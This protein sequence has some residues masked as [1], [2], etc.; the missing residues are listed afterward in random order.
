MSSVTWEGE[1]CASMCFSVQNEALKVVSSLVMKLS[2]RR[3]LVE[4][5]EI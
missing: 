3:V 4:R 2:S 5:E 1:T